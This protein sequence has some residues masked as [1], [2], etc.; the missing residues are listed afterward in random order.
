MALG[1][2]RASSVAGFL[3]RLG[4][5]RARIRETSRGELD[6]TGKD[7]ATWQIDRRV[8]IVLAEGS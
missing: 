2:R 6:A 1:A 7:E 4:V 8:D 3:D 5:D